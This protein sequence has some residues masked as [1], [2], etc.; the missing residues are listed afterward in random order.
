MKQ[1]FTMEYYKQNPIKIG[2]FSSFFS[3]FFG[4]YALGLAFEYRVGWIIFPLSVS[5]I[6]GMI[7]GASAIID[8][9]NT[10]GR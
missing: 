1:I 7:F 5:T 3:L 10:K 8:A 9:S 2:L 4:C 6:A